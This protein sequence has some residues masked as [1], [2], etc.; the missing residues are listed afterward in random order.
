MLQEDPRFMLPED[1]RFCWV[2]LEGKNPDCPPCHRPL[3]KILFANKL[4]L[5]CKHEV[6]VACW[7]K[8]WNIK[9]PSGVVPCPLCRKDN[10][11]VV[12]PRARLL[13]LTKDRDPDPP[14]PEP[15]TFDI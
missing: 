3:D 14:Y 4:L 11:F 8:W 10:K 5:S 13:D 9:L 15:P 1:H 2:T 6:C 7:R 12:P